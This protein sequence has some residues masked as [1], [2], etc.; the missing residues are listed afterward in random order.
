MINVAV[1]CFVID[2]IRN[3]VVE[4]IGIFH[5]RFA[6]PY[7]RDNR[8]L[9]FRATKT[10]P[11]KSLALTLARTYAS[12]AAGNGSFGRASAESAVGTSANRM[13]TIAKRSPNQTELVGFL[14]LPAAFDPMP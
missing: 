9:P 8:I 12:S 2:P 11:L 7:P 1:N 14:M 6:S 13:T 5:S 10:A 4:L 3:L